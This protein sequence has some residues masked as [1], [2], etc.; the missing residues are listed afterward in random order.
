MHRSLGSFD[1]SLPPQ[2]GDASISMDG[3]AAL[4]TV[5]FNLLPEEFAVLFDLL[6]QLDGGVGEAHAGFVEE[7]AGEGWFDC[8]GVS[9]VAGGGFSGYFAHVCLDNCC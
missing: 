4:G 7:G 5:H 9:T 3:T 6:G 2:R 1:D 8:G